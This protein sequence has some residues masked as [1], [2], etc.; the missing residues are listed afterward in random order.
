MLV[1]IGC[2]G[3]SSDQPQQEAKQTEQQTEQAQTQEPEQAKANDAQTQNDAPGVQQTEI[4]SADEPIVEKIDMTNSPL[5][6]TIV[7]INEMASGNSGALK[8]SAAGNAYDKND[9]L[10]FKSGD[11]VYIVY[12]EDGTYAGKRLHKLIGKTLKIKGEIKKIDDLQILII[13]SI[14]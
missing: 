10:A 9:V 5:T 12:N 11:Q 3:K 13:T 7:S 2:G 8:A 6:G 14:E 1:I 4:K